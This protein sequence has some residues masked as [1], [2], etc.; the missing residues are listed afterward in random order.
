MIGQQSPVF[1]KSGNRT[2][3]LTRVTRMMLENADIICPAF[4]SHNVR[5]IAHASRRAAYWLGAREPRAANAHRN[6][7]APERGRR[8]ESRL[9]IYAP[10]GHLI[11][12]MAYLIRRLIE[13]TANESFLR[14]SFSGEVPLEALL[15]RLGPQVN[16]HT[17][18]MA[19]TAV[20]ALADRLSPLPLSHTL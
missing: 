12:G 15:V 8:N 13:N 14:Q 11:P 5:S 16:G 20:P 4:A 3:R 18:N 1:T 9:R 10:F 6:G 19:K 17:Q 2:R 7:R